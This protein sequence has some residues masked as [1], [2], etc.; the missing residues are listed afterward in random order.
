[1]QITLRGILNTRNKKF[2]MIHIL[3][4]HLLHDNQNKHKFKIE[5]TVSCSISDTSY[6]SVT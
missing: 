3:Q 1:M 4:C 2:V 5:K 6:D